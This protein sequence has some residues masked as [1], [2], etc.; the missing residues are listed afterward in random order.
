MSS[1]A[2][3][4]ALVMAR[5]MRR[6]AIKP[7]RAQSW[8]ASAKRRAMGQAASSGLRS[9]P[10][11]SCSPSSKNQLPFV[12]C[13]AVTPQPSSATAAMKASGLVGW[14]LRRTRWMLAAMVL[15]SAEVCRRAGRKI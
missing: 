13:R 2:P 1:A 5:S 9:S 15:R 8:R 3:I 6:S 10:A 11:A 7:R 12:F 14:R 4:R